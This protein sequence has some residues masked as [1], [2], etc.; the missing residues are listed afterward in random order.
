[1]IE[2]E[3]PTIQEQMGK[4]DMME[5]GVTPPRRFILLPLGAL[6]AKQIDGANEVHCLQNTNVCGHTHS[7]TCFLLSFSPYILAVDL[8]EIFLLTYFNNL[9]L[10]Q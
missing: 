7:L 5:L 6:S 10:P 2:N 1:M 3:W 8:V 9:L 4:E